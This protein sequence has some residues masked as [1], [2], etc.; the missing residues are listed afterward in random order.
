MVRKGVGDGFSFDISP[1]LR[2]YSLLPL[3]VWLSV[4][5]SLVYSRIKAALGINGLELC[6]HL[7][8]IHP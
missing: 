5:L 2:E 7:H 3:S 6:L 1:L 4:R 8:G